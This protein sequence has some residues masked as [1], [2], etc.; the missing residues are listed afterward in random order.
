MDND[1]GF[2]LDRQGD[3]LIR[4]LHAIE[5]WNDDPMDGRCSSRESGGSGKEAALVDEVVV[6]AMGS[7]AADGHGQRQGAVET[8]GAFEPELAWCNVSA[9]GRGLAG[10]SDFCHADDR[11]SF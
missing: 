5:L 8:P 6:G 10:I 9:Y 1:A 2:R 11:G 7:R 4:F 3:S